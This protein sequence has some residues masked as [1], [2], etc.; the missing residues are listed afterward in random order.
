MPWLLSC[1]N[2]GS[3]TFMH[4]IVP[5]LRSRFPVLAGVAVIALAL[6]IG[7]HLKGNLPDAWRMIRVPAD[8]PLFGD[9]RTVTHSIDC[10]L[11]GQDPYTV[12]AFDP[13]HRVYNYPPV[14][15]ALRFVGVTSRTSNFLGALFTAMSIGSFL[16]LLEARTWI[17][18]IIAF[19]AVT[20]RAVLLSVERGNIDQVVLFLLVV[21]FLLIDRMSHKIKPEL[22]G[23]LVVFLTILK[24]YPVASAIVL[25]RNRKGA[26]AAVVTAALA[27]A[28]L[29]VTAGHELPLILANT[30]QSI[31]GS[32]WS[33]PLNVA[34]SDHLHR[35]STGADPQ[36]RYLPSVVALLFAALSVL[37]GISF[38][39][40]LGRCLPPLDF[41]RANGCIAVGCLAIYCFVFVLGSNFDYRLIFFVGI[42]A[43][44]VDDLNQRKSLRSL[45]AAI[46]FLALMWKP[47]HLSLMFGLLDGC[48][49]ALACAWLGTSL[50]DNLNVTLPLAPDSL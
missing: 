41:N 23:C 9:T 33:F 42:L 31:F 34:I 25:V 47:Y 8:S 22:R 48:T 35:S 40:Q 19:F 29:L 13:W 28:A 10:L 45:P 43:Y 26:P 3:K 6:V 36:Y 7:F 30:P 14:W 4:S 38:R 15:L 2:I 5:F 16:L 39:K 24:I 27:V 21:G 12:R 37:A 44:M 32:F 20:S 11:S 50:L 1:L 17:A 46:L 18:G 49:F